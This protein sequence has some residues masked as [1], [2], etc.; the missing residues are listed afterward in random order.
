MPVLQ[1]EPCILV[2]RDSDHV[3][4]GLLK[5]L[6]PARPVSLSHSV[7]GGGGGLETMLKSVFV[8]DL[9]GVLGFEGEDALVLEFCAFFKEFEHFLAIKSYNFLLQVS[10]LV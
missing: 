2:L 7:H 9:N 5:H 3:C 6:V 8:A 4:Q 1:K 10:E